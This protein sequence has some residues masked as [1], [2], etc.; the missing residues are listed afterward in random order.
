MFVCYDCCVLSNRGLCDEL[1]TR[2][3][4]SYRLRCVVVCDLETS[5]MRRPWLALGRR[6]TMGERGGREKGKFFLTGYVFP[7]YNVSA[8]LQY[9]IHATAKRNTGHF[10]LEICVLP[11][12]PESHTTRGNS[13]TD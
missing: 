3:E 8:Q 1:I 11:K 13:D 2:P 12:S 6:A 4:E 10:E 9:S 5:R 7:P